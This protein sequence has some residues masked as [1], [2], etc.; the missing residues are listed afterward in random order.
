[1]SAFGGKADIATERASALRRPV[2]K[3]CYLR[4]K[5]FRANVRQAGAMLDGPRQSWPRVPGDS[6]TRRFFDTPQGSAWTHSAS[7]SRTAMRRGGLRRAMAVVVRQVTAFNR[8]IPR[9]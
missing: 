9:R 3:S 2:R 4:G 1:M 8:A 6:M 5:Q 7:K